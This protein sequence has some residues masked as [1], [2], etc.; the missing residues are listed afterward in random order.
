MVEYLESLYLR[1][2]DIRI[3]V[4]AGPI[5]TDIKSYT[6]EDQAMKTLRVRDDGVSPELSKTKL[7]V[8]IRPININERTNLV[9]TYI[10]V[11]PT[12]LSI[13]KTPLDWIF[14]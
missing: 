11:D 5:L 3:R 6:V 8:A 1:F 9:A 7:F 10:S 14:G 4:F 2:I 12:S 13:P